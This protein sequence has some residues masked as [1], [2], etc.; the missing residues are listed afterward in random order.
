MYK[1]FIS[2]L[3][4]ISN[5]KKGEIFHFAIPDWPEKIKRGLQ[6]PQNCRQGKCCLLETK[7]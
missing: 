4:S 2:T 1:I 6:I 5:L 7:D 3:I